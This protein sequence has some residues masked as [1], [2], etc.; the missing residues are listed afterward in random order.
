[1]SKPHEL[2]ATQVYVPPFGGI[3]DAMEY[4]LEVAPG[5]TRPL[6]RHWY[7]GAGVPFATKVN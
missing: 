2:V 5:I 3:A 7:V 1:M 6:N 4:V